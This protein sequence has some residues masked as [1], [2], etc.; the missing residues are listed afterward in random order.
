MN[1]K[2]Q[3]SDCLRLPSFL[4]LLP[5]LLFGCGE[6]RT[7]PI[8][9]A[10]AQAQPG[11]GPYAEEQWLGLLGDSG[12][13]GAATSSSLK[14][15]WDSLGKL[16]FDTVATLN[17]IKS[18][19][20]DV[21]QIPNA[22]SF[23]LK[24]RAEPLQRVIFSKKEKDE[25]GKDRPKLNLREKSSSL[26]DIPEYSYGYLTGRAL[27]L[28]ANRIVMVA[29][30]G[31]RV[32]SIYLQ[33]QRFVDVAANLPSHVLVSFSANDICG[34]ELDGSKEEFVNDFKKTA[35]REFELVMRN[36]KA[37]PKLGTKFIIMAP[38]DVPQVLTNERL[39]Q[40]KI[41]FEGAGEKSCQE[42]RH[43]T[44][45]KNELGN[46]MQ[47]TMTDMCK[48]IVGLTPNDK[49]RIDKIRTFQEAQIATWK[50]IVDELNKKVD[51]S[52]GWAFE[53]NDSTRRP[54]YQAG[55][56]A[57]DCFHPGPKAHAKIA[58]ELIKS[59]GKL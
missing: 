2:S 5:T 17:D 42:V 36:M 43:R 51:R 38:L 9:P 45:A 39:L 7:G 57:N 25:A 29:Q 44:V 53:F 50:E 33:M 16:A 40:Q 8:T 27:G 11:G 3:I 47:N 54:E 13:S 22:S 32:G 28:P 34:T 31:Q 59:L 19:A 4:L 46:L 35:I 18:P 52:Q 1:T 58:T 55:D 20:A 26:I 30:D 49:G 12:I 6:Q 15:T 48:A 41:A 37:H 24:D 23:G 10:S 14:M 56:L 21:S